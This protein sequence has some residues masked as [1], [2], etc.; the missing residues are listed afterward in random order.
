LCEL[1]GDQGGDASRP[2][3]T[4]NGIHFTAYGYWKS[5]RALREQQLF[6]PDQESSEVIKIKGQGPIEFKVRRLP[7]PTSPNAGP[8][9]GESKSV[10][11]MAEGLSPGRYGLHLDGKKSSTATAGA[12]A[13]GVRLPS[14]LDCEQVERLRAAIIEKNRL[15]FYRWRPQNETYLFGFRKHEQGQNAR[16]IPQF[17][18][19]VAKAET[20]IGKLRWPVAHRYELI[21]LPEGER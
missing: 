11:L 15:Y 8:G 16:E 3:L 4:D 13:K 9:V 7:D 5:A 12:W 6:G 2:F 21:K 17:D 20:E 18:P 19:L 10:L 1:L 14:T